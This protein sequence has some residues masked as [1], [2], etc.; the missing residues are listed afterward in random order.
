MNIKELT[1][2]ILA[3]LIMASIVTTVA[4]WKANDATSLKNTELKEDFEIMKEKAST[5]RALLLE[6]QWKDRVW[7]LYYGEQ[8]WQFL[9][10]LMEEYNLEVK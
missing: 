4:A 10:D 2:Y 1:I 6:C 9:L 7:M 8:G 5:T 3:F